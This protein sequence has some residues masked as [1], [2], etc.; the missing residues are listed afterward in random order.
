M[1]YTEYAFGRYESDIVAA[2]EEYNLNLRD[3]EVESFSPSGLAILVEKIGERRF[4]IHINLQE[5]RIIAV[6]QIAGAPLENDAEDQF[7]KYTSFMK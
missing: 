3:L 7:A 1:N 6:K 2:A 4:K 5:G